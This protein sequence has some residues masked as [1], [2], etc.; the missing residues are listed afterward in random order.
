MELPATIWSMQGKWF[1]MVMNYENNLLNVR[2]SYILSQWNDIGT[3]IV[4]PES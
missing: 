4:C 2:E 3:C 1:V